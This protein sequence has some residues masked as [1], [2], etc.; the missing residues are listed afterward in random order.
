MSHMSRRTTQLPAV[1]MVAVCSG[2]MYD[3]IKTVVVC[4]FF[5]MR[6]VLQDKLIQHSLRSLLC[7]I[8]VYVQLSPCPVVSQAIVVLGVR[9]LTVQ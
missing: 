4:Y 2:A 5:S 8:V 1:S 6:E 9:S 3:A 7:M